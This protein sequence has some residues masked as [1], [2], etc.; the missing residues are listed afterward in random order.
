M[1]YAQVMRV[2]S[3]YIITPEIRREL[4]SVQAGGPGAMSAGTGIVRG[5]VLHAGKGRGGFGRRKSGGND[6]MIE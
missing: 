3:H 1:F 2:H 6:M 5:K 4:F